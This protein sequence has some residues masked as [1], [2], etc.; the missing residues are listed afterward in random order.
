MKFLN[1]FSEAFSVN[2]WWSWFCILVFC[3]PHG[4]EGAEGWEDWSSDPDW[5][6]SFGGGNDLDL[7]GWRSKGCDFLWK[8]FSDSLVHSGSSWH[9]DVGIQVLSNIDIAFHDW[10]EGQFVDTWVLLSGEGGLEQQFRASESLVANSDHI[11][12]G[13][14]EGLVIGWGCFIFLEFS[15]IVN[16]DVAEFFL[17]VSDDFSFSWGAEAVSFLLQDFHQ[18]IGQVSSG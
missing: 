10:L 4:L 16:G 3:D 17:D 8:S 6:L 14:F 1:V 5:E 15:I 18:V 2:Y 12:V 13:E 9:N 7:H 11:S